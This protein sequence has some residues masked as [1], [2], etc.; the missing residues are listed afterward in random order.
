MTNGLCADVLEIVIK[1]LPSSHAAYTSSLAMACYSSRPHRGM[2]WET[3][4][5]CCSRCWMNLRRF[6]YKA[7][8]YE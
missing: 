4:Y 7:E 1:D 5:N 8:W 6:M 2:N 3:R